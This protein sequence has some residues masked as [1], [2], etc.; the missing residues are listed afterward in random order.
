MFPIQ[1]EPEGTGAGM[2]GVGHQQIRAFM[3][4]GG[5]IVRKPK[6]WGPKSHKRS[7]AM[8]T[9]AGKWM[10]TQKQI[11]EALGGSDKAP[12]NKRTTDRLRSLG[13]LG[14]TK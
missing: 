12:L 2:L 3:A 11:R 10:D 9:E 6:M 4:S 5:Q 13:Y 1:D 8:V 14:G 7:I